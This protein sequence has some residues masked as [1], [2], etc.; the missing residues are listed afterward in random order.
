MKKMSSEIIAGIPV[1]QT[2]SLRKVLNV[3]GESV[4][5]LQAE[6]GSNIETK[7]EPLSERYG[8]RIVNPQGRRIQMNYE[9]K[10]RLD[11]TAYNPLD[12][13]GQREIVELL[14]KSLPAGEEMMPDIACRSVVI[15]VD[16]SE[17][18]E[19]AREVTDVPVEQS[20]FLIT[21]ENDP[22]ERRSG[23]Q[24]RRPV[25]VVIAKNRDLTVDVQGFKGRV[26]NLHK[27]IERRRVYGTIKPL[28]IAKWNG[29]GDNYPKCPEEVGRHIYTT[30]LSEGYRELNFYYTDE[31]RTLQLDGWQMG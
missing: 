4:I 2:V 11:G 23:D 26:L 3:F 13:K 17:L 28:Y 1:L 8:M 31:Q 16:D 20:N 6:G 18:A 12:G 9:Q 27:V 30:Y 10:R 7:R 29:P 24:A 25:D 19:I 14:E 5:G 22:A 15:E 21:W